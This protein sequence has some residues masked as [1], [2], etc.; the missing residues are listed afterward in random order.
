MQYQP[1]LIN[2]KT[3]KF[4]GLDPW[5]APSDAFPILINAQVNKQV[6]EKRNA[7]SLFAQ[8]KHGSTAQTTT[9]ITGIKN[10]VS[11]GMPQLLI[12]DTKRVNLYNPIDL[13]MTDIA[14]SDIF[15]GRAIDLF[16]FANWLDVAYMTN[17]VDRIYKYTGSGNVSVFNYQFDSTEQ[18]TN[19]LDTCRFIFVL[20][21]RLCFLETTE[22]GTWHPNRFRYSPVLQVDGL[23]SGG[24]Y[25]DCPTTERICAAGM[26]NNELHIFMESNDGGSLWKIRSTGNSDTPYEWKKISGTEGCRSPYSGVEFKDGLGVIGLNNILFYDGFKIQELDVPNLRDIV[27]D[28]FED[29]LIRYCFGYNQ[30]DKKHILWTYAAKDSTVPDRILD[31]NIIDNTWCTHKSAQTFFLNCIGSFNNQ[32]VPSWVELDEVVASDGAL[33]SEIDVDS[34]EI[35]GSPYPFTLIG[36]RNSRIYKWDDGGYDGTDD[37]NGKIEIDIQSAE[38]NPFTKDGKKARLEKIQFFVDND[39]T[40]S[41]TVS[42]YKDSSTTAWKTQVASCDLSNGKGFTTVYAG[43]EIGNF[44]KIKI[45]HTEK[46]N[47][48]RIHAMI[49]YFAPEGYLDL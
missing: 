40:A 12:M 49:F 22:L 5:L 48:P 13:T 16:H 33:V 42:F 41:F 29:T 8:M 38:L 30:Q 11:K 28:E 1:F 23:Q 36:C 43:G 25:N 3:G 31:F 27:K 14:G 21:D 7:Y 47:R 6:L 15:A 24:G 26:V 35:L 18:A 4:L 46:S 37:A 10:Y 45:S 39:S 17:N 32:V 9:A 34:R 19:H 44:H 20:D 2:F